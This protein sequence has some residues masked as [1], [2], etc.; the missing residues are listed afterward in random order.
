[1]CCAKNVIEDKLLEIKRSIR[2]GIYLFQIRTGH[3]SKYL[4][5]LVFFIA[6]RLYY[7]SLLNSYIYEIL[8][9]GRLQKIT[10]PPASELALPNDYPK[11]DCAGGKFELLR[12]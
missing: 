4:S 3:F 2:R 12:E 11:L 6:K 8:D 5:K 10:L 7:F 9:L 1:M